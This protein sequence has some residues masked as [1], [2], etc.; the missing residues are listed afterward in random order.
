[1]EGAPLDVFNKQRRNDYANDCRCRR[2][3]GNLRL[4]LGR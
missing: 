1:M 4:G 3:G 2:S